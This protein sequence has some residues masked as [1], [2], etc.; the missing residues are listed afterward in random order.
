[1]IRILSDENVHADIVS[2]LRQ[3]GFDLVTAVDSG[4]AGRKDIEILDYAEQH[5][6]LLLSGDKD[7][8]GLIEFGNLWGRGRVLLLRYQILNV[9]RIVQDIA[10]T[11]HRES[12]NLT[13]SASFVIVLSESGYRVR[14]PNP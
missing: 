3:E 5:D 14:R 13:Q 2:G 11:L 8:G 1:V 4:L 7:F 10:R 12:E 6:L 9:P